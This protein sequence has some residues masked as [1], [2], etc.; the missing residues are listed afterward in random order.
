MTQ[1]KFPLERVLIQGMRTGIYVLIVLL[2]LFQHLFQEQFLNWV[3]LKH[4]YFAAI[5][6]LC[7]HIL[8]LIFARSFFERR[9]LVGFSFVLDLVLLSYLL[10]QTELN[11]S[12]FLFLDLL[13]I[14]VCG[15]VFGTR[16]ALMLAAGFS[17]ATTLILALG[18]EMKSLTFFFLLILNNLAFFSVAAISGLLT[19]QLEA[20][21]LSLS[22]LRKIN[23]SIV[24]TIPTGLLTVDVKGRVL[25]V[26][27]GASDIFG[28]LD[29]ES[30]TMATVIPGFSWREALGKGKVEHVIQNEDDT[31][32][33][34]VQVLN[35]NLP[36]QQAYLVLVEDQTQ[37]RKLEYAVRQSEKLAAVGQL[38]A[39]IA[40]E[41]R[42]PLAG[43]SGSIE[44][45]SEQTANETDKKL[46]KIILREIDRLNNLVG[47]FLDFAKPEKPPIEVHD[48]GPM[49]NEVLDVVSRDSK[50]RQ[51]VVLERNI[52]AGLL[53]RVH[54]DKLKQ[55]FLNIVINAFQAMEKSEMAR[56]SAKAEVRDK[57]VIIRFSDTGCGMEE[58]TRKRMFEPFHT[59]KPKGT[60]LGLA[61]TLKILEL[62]RG[63][64]FVESEKG[65]GTDF[66][67]RFP[68]A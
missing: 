55:A 48:I 68:L 23:E 31:K 15:M 12:I 47:D 43:I 42:N 10:Y 24:E 63:Q 7:V 21:G 20:Q 62:H 8:S 54:K 49:L 14:L 4:F 67:I 38:A 35:Q 65:K 25:Q 28:E 66:E 34:T 16:G 57:H 36:D 40:H 2:A 11:Q 33:Y 13:V 26:N 6:G 44:L 3:L 56:F 1:E 18:P 9:L 41:I 46:N 60:G 22:A 51:D 27:P 32:V 17:I 5:V 19:D 50:L 37:V 64:I 30:A 45:L 52:T 29:F 53:I 39:G 58:S 61:I 59:T